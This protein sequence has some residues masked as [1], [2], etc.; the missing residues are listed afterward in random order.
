MGLRGQ[1]QSGGGSGGRFL[2]LFNVLGADVVGGEQSQERR[3]GSG[4]FYG[5]AAIGFFALNDADHG[6]DGHVGFPGGFDGVDCGGAGSANVVDYDHARSFA[7]EAFDATAGAMGLFRFANQKTVKQWSAGLRLGA[8]G[9][10]GGHIGNDGV[11]T[12]GETSDSLGIDAVLLK[13]LENRVAGLA[14]ALGVE[15]GGAAID[16]VVAGS[17]GGEL[18]L[19]EAKAG[20]GENGEKLL[21]VGWGIHQD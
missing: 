20:A 1:L 4:G 17:A 21:R 18:E 13:Q 11:G 10:G 9:A 5:G 16:V 15:C 14:S 2:N 8:P 19:A 6:G 7:A 12:H 3:A